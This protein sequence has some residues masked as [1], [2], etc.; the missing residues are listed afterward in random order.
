MEPA[1][2]LQP[3]RS[4]E[5]GLPKPGPRLKSPLFVPEW[6]ERRL[7][8]ELPEP[9]A[10]EYFLDLSGAFQ[11]SIGDGVPLRPYRQMFNQISN[12]IFLR[13]LQDAASCVSSREFKPLRASTFLA[14]RLQARAPKETSSRP[15]L[16]NKG[17]SVR[18]RNCPSQSRP[19][20]S[21]L[22][23]SASPCHQEAR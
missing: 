6:F 2:L 10:R 8:L 21:P 22:R 7:R 19:P 14:L 5:P 1:R 15:R 12:A 20:S 11:S 16:R 17:S 13:H 3:E 18:T 4:P 23:A 9:R